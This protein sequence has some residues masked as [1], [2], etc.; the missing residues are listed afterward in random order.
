MPGEAVDVPGVKEAKIR[1][2]CVLERAVEFGEGAPGTDLLIGRVVKFHIDDGI[3]DDGKIDVRKLAVVSRLAGADYAEIG[4]I[5][6]IE[7]PE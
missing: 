2:E 5:F 7:R 1:M 3:Y 4:N 6:T